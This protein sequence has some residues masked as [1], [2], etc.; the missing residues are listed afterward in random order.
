MIRARIPVAGEPSFVSTAGVDG[1]QFLV[2][3]TV[4]RGGGLSVVRVILAG[5]GTVSDV[6][7]GDT[8]RTKLRAEFDE[9]GQRTRVRVGPAPGP[10]VAWRI[11]QAVAAHRAARKTLSPAVASILAR[12]APVEGEVAHPARALSPVADAPLHIAASLDLHGEPEFRFVVP[13]GRAVDAVAAYVEAHG[14]GADDPEGEA[15]RAAFL[16]GID[17]FYTPAER[18]RLAT[19]LRDAALAF[20][21]SQR[22]A[23]ALSAVAAAEALEDGSPA[24][25][26]PHEIPFVMAMFYKFMLVRREMQNRV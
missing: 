18:A 5:D 22:P 24:A 23:K 11:H 17:A 21:A 25:P 12:V 6:T 19:Q 10:Y 16:K 1:I 13:P 4:G 7:H 26:P 20:A 2:H 15:T 3:V 8:S 9:L 14:S